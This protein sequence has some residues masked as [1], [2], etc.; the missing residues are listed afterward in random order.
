MRKRCYVL[1]TALLLIWAFS[2]PVMGQPTVSGDLS[3]QFGPGEYIVV[4]NCQVPAGQTLE[5]LP[6]TSFLFS[7]H[8]TFNVNGT[9][10][11]DGTPVDSINFVRQFPDETCKHGGVR[12]NAGPNGST[13][14]YCHIDFARNTNYPNWSGGGI[15]CNHTEVSISNCLITNCYAYNLGGGIY[16]SYAPMQISD[17]IFIGNEAGNGGGVYLS[18]SN[19]SEIRNSAFAKNVSTST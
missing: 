14:S 12:F 11:A 15:F 16:A 1:L 4:G 2:Y 17:C 8:Y 13:M 18:Y 7:G 5:I 19:R 9:L 3:G 6:G 10:H